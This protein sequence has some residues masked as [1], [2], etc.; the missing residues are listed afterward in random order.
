MSDD[1]SRLDA[2]RQSGERQLNECHA[3]Q[4]RERNHGHD[5][6]R[7]RRPAQA[8]LPRDLREQSRVLLSVCEQELEHHVDYEHSAPAVA[9]VDDSRRTAARLPLAAH[10]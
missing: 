6:Q 10:R 9:V 5:R 7:V 4:G 3:Q 8:E 2:R 1:L